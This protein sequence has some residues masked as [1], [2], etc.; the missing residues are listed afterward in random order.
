MKGEGMTREREGMV[1]VISGIWKGT[2]ERTNNPVVTVGGV[3]PLT[4]LM[5]LP[6]PVYKWQTYI[7]SDHTSHAITTATHP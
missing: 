2:R 7:T 5:A 3:M 1:Y 6:T 4:S